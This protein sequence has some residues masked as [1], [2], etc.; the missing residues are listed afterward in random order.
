MIIWLETL[1]CSRNQVDSEVMLARLVAAGH[2]IGRNPSVADVI[3]VN[4]CGFISDA[5]DEAVGTILEL[6]EYKINGSCRRLVVTGCLP[7]RFKKD[8]L[9]SSLPEVDVFLGTGAVDSIVQAV[10]DGSIGSKGIIAFFPDPC[11]REFQGY[12]LPRKL[13]LDYSAYVKISE[14]CNRKCTYCIIPKL[15]GKQ[16]SRPVDDIICETENLILQGVKEIIFT[17]ENTTDYGSDFPCGSPYKLPCNKPECDKIKCDKIDLA[18]LFEKLSVKLD[19]IFTGAPPVHQHCNQDKIFHG[20]SNEN[21][22]GI[23]DK[24]WLRL[25]YTHPSSLSYKIIKSI[26]E[27]DNFCNYYDVPVQHASSK[28]LKKMG[29]PYTM[30]DLYSLFKSIKKTDRSAVLRTTII[31]GFPGET[32]QDFKILL[33]FIEDIKFNHLGVFTYSDSDDIKSHNLPDHVPKELARER[34]DIIMAKQAKISKRINKQRLDR[35]YK[36]LVEENPDD[37]IFLGRTAFQAPDVDGITFIYGSG[38]EIGTFVDV[39][40]IETYE[41]DLAGEVENLYRTGP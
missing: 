6:A 27:S 10:E 39:R 11:K 41:Y 23:S 33:K 4:T 38:L 20:N 35:I 3:I 36:V 28:I 26:S 18:Y 15:R 21:F 22:H 31:T 19:E 40:I 9:T 29:R 37:G 12:P 16:R 30:G 24:I 32:E 25:L 5:A 2:S 7:E 34:H 14:G 8:D 1:G 13:T 17:G